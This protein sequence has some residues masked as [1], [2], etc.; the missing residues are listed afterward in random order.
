MSKQSLLEAIAQCK[1]A[2]HPPFDPAQFQAAAE[3][4]GNILQGSGR[5]EDAVIWH[6]QAHQPE[7]DFAEVYTGLGRIYYRQERWEEAIAAYTQ[8]LSLNPD[9]EEPHWQLAAIYHQRD[10]RQAAL[11][12]WT[13]ALAFS[14][15]KATPD[16]H[17]KFGRA[18][19]KFGQ[20]AAALNCYRRAIYV[21]ADYVP[22]YR[23]LAETYRKLGQWQEAIA[24]YR[25][26]ITRVSQ[27][28][29]L[30]HKLGKL[31]QARGQ[32][33]EAMAIFE[34]AIAHDPS[35]RWNYHDRNLLLIQQQRWDEVIAACHATLAQHPDTF[36]AYTQMGRA[37]LAMGNREGAIAAH[38]KTCALQGWSRCETEN[39]Q[40]TQDCFSAKIPIVLEHLHDL[41][42][43]PHLQALEI[44]SFEGMSACWFLDH[45]LTHATAHLTC[46]DRRFQA[47]FELNITK[48]G[49]ASRVTPHTGPSQHIVPTLPDNH[50]DLIFIDGAPTPEARQQDGEQAWPKLKSG[51]WLMFVGYEAAKVGIDAGLRRLKD[52][53]KIRHRHHHLI[54]Q[55]L[56]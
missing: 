13:Q 47:E 41:M 51:G 15:E 31:L 56:S 37:F 3:R 21:D 49:A 9:V 4:I 45:I 19:L 16:G 5:F 52:R 28:G 42:G 32:A 14:P 20:V 12:H 26:A 24:I 40:F 7:P 36:W 38:Q 11:H 34:A 1:Q 54:V 46:I 50:F 22:A 55:K 53:V 29:A 10:Q 27:P 44:G 39:Y 8:V 2:I 17:V 48:T 23:E 30:Y 6:T 35:Y 43:Q 18:L 25:E 33:G